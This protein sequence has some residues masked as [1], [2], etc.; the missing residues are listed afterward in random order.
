MD[1]I[2]LTKEQEEKL[3]N[4]INCFCKDLNID[5]SNLD[6]YNF[7]LEHSYS[8]VL[9]NIEE[10]LRVLKVISLEEIEEV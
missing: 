1:E 8:V 5:L 4:V 2:Y 7:I 6:S 10:Y 3:Q 9:N